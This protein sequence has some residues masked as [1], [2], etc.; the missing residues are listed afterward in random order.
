MNYISVLTYNILSSNLATLMTNERKNDN[1]VYSE[2][3]MNNTTRFEKISLF[4]KENIIIN[5][6][7]IIC[8]QEVTEEWLILFAQLF[9]SLNYRYLNIQYGRIINGNMGVLI[10]YPNKFG[11][12]KSEFYHVGQHIKIKDKNSSYASGKTNI[13]IFLILEDKKI[14][15]KFG[16]ATY[17]MPCEPTIQEIGLLHS[18]L[19]YK[20][21]I[22]FM[23]YIPWILTTDFN[24]IPNTLGYKYMIKHDIGC[25][26]KDKL[27]Y[28]PITNHSY[29]NN[30]EFSGCID[31]IFYNKNN[32]ECKKIIIDKIDNIIPDEKQ[33]SDHIPIIAI[34]NLIL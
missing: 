14:N 16:I 32:L 10:A 1:I 20:K 18:K 7:L 8:L 34:F 15:F 23:K 26:W 2:Y 11:I 25:I 27:G 28:Y 29:I 22:S 9:S 17:H 13:A 31:Y 30:F 12:L 19:L 24:M 33:P 3:I 5:K 21:I 6:D 4:I